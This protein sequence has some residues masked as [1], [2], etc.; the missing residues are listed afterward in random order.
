MYSRGFIRLA[1][2]SRKR[3]AAWDYGPRVQS[4]WTAHGTGD[5]TGGIHLWE[6]APGGIVVSLSDHK[7]AITSLSWRGDGALLASGK[8]GSRLEF[9]QRQYRHGRRAGP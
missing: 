8:A 1:L 9:P 2:L 6:S 3:Y 5:R 7:D 4:R